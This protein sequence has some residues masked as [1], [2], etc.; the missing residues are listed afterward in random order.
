MEATVNGIVFNI[1]RFAIHDGP[2]IRT[3]VFLKGCP[4]KCFWCHNPESWQRDPEISFQSDKCIG[5]G[6]CFKVCTRHCH[7]MENGEH[8]FCREKCAGCGRCA[9]KCYAE[10]IEIV[11]REMSVAE[12]LSEVMKDKPFYDNSGG[13]M[14]VSGGE[15]M[16][17]FEFTR[18]LLKAAK[19]AGIHNCLD[20]CG[21]APFDD[22]SQILKDV[23]IFL[24]DLKA[25]NS[26]KHYDWTGVPLEGILDNLF[27]LDDAGA[28]IILRCPLIPGF[29]DDDEHLK[30]IAVTANKL[31]HVQEIN[32]LPYNPLGRDKNKYLGYEDDGV[33]FERASE[34]K[35]KHYLQ[36]VGKHTAIPV[37]RV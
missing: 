12:V 8:I 4:L 27:R 22:Y 24:Y 21:F 16:L 36:I 10:A 18:A 33:R 1:Q 13:G 34:N 31:R 11:G 2:G 6:W 5:C 19:K 9:E 26:D 37:S 3:A 30:N 7:R 25:G 35:I 29:N 17:Q 32:L 23:D 20:T 14:T 28:G 15:P